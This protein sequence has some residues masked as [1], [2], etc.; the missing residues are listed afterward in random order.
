MG[1]GHFSG[2]EIDIISGNIDNFI[3]EDQR[4]DLFFILTNQLELKSGEEFLF[5]VTVVLSAAAC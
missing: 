2:S 3:D 5:T 1:F 4:I